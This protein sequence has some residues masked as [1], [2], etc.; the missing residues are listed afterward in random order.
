MYK[1]SLKKLSDA[2]YELEQQQDCKEQVE[3]VKIQI[4]QVCCI[5]IV[6]Y[7]PNFFQ[8][9]ALIQ[10]WLLQLTQLKQDLVSLRQHSQTYTSTPSS[11][12]LLTQSTSMPSSAQPLSAPSST[13]RMVTPL[14]VQQQ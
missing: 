3:Q 6:A 12:L 4:A 8:K 1:T 2:L 13:P 10:Q 9:N 11:S 7:L 5:I 14:Q